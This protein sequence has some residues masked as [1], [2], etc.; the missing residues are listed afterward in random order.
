[1]KEIDSLKDRITKLQ[2]RQMRMLGKD[3]SNLSLKEVQ[4]LEKQLSESLLSVKAK[5]DQLLMEQPEH[6]RRQQPRFLL[7]RTGLQVLMET[8]TVN[9]TK[10][11]LMLLCT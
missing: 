8:A 4:Q 9:S 7:R 3:L 5:K 11:I 2:L 6:S 1:M 10:H